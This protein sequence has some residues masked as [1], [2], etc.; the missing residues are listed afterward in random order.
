MNTPATPEF[1]GK[2]AFATSLG[3]PDKAPQG[4]ARYRVERNGKTYVFVGA[5]PKFLFQALPGMEA[6]AQRK[7]DTRR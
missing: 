1:D 7:W 4:N 6:R 3:G 2:C 5:V